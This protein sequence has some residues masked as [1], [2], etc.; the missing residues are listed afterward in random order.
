MLSCCCVL[1]CARELQELVVEEMVAAVDALSRE[2]L[3]E[4]LRVALNSSAAVTTLRSMEALWPL[5]A[6]MLPMPM[7]HDM[8]S[9]MNSRV[10]LTDEDRQ[11]LDTIESLLHVVG[12]GAEP[13]GTGADIGSL[14]GSSMRTGQTVMKGAGELMPIMPDLLPGVQATFEMFVKQLVRRMALR[15]ADDLAPIA[16]RS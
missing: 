6:M 4:A 13:G 1:T 14:L 5:H 8:L 7:P 12:G 2:A 3:G 16:A 9:A 15:L 11:A 10:T